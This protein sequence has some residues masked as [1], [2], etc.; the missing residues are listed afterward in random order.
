MQYFARWTGLF[1]CLD[2]RE[3]VKQKE[4]RKKRNIFSSPLLPSA[5]SISLSPVM[6]SL[7]FRNAHSS[8]VLFLCCKSVDA[9]L[10][11]SDPIF[12]V[13]FLLQNSTCSRWLW[14]LFNWQFYI[15]NIGQNEVRNHNLPLFSLWLSELDLSAILRKLHAIVQSHPFAV[16]MAARS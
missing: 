12:H 13:W 6:L 4:T 15:W 2:E 10:C 5:L 1:R 16:L 11:N 14:T 7:L 9:I 3:E 8:R